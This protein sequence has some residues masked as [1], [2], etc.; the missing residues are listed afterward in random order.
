[1][2][3]LSDLSLVLNIVL[4]EVEVE[5]FSTQNYLENIM[6]KDDSWYHKSVSSKQAVFI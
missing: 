4:V 6:D 3:S 1:M 5:Y 2:Q